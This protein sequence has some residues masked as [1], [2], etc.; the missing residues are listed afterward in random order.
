[1]GDITI[2]IL[3]RKKIFEGILFQLEYKDIDN[4][5]PNIGEIK[6]LGIMNIPTSDY[7]HFVNK[8]IDSLKNQNK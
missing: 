3:K 2:K 5:L 8:L 7:N 4:I 6:N 1:M